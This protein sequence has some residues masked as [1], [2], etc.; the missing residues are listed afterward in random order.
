MWFLMSCTVDDEVIYLNDGVED[1]AT[2]EEARKRF[3]FTHTIKTQPKAPMKWTGARASSPAEAD[4]SLY[5]E[6]NNLQL[7][8]NLDPLVDAYLVR[9][10]DE[11]GKV[12]YEKAINAGSI[13]GLNIDISTYAAGRYT[14]TVENAQES[15]TGEFETQTSGIEIVSNDKEGLSGSIYNLQGQRIGSL[16]KGLNIVNG[17]KLYV[18]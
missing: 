10:T 14:V 6:Y 5:G 18:K 16:Q 11:S 4:Q 1:G 12:V 7:G 9:I 2:P 13:M 15:F 8:I 3:D 17:Q